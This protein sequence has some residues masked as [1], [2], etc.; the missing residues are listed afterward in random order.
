MNITFEELQKVSAEIIHVNNLGISEIKI[1]QSDL[2]TDG[3]G[4][5]FLSQRDFE[6]FKQRQ[7]QKNDCEHLNHGEA[8]MASNGFL[9]FTCNDCGARF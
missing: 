2:M 5:L 1:M 4:I 9:Y 7:D 8:Q 6:T 3:I